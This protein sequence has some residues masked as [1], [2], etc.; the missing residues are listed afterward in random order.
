MTEHETKGHE[1]VVASMF[2]RIAPGYD[3]ANRL[4]SLGVDTLWRQRL[5]RRV[6]EGFSL[7]SGRKV[8]DLAAGTLDVSLALARRIPGVTVAATD[9][10]LPMLQAG[11]RKL[12]RADAYER[13]RIVR[14]TG[15]ALALPLKTDSMNAVT[16]AFGLRNMRPRARALA[17]AHR[18]LC[19]GGRL[20]VLE[21]GSAKGR[22]WG[23][24]YNWYLQTLLPFL[25]GAITGDREAYRYL[26][27]TVTDFPPAQELGREMEEAGFTAVTWEK[28]W[29]GIVFL[30]AAEKPY[31][32]SGKQGDCE[33]VRS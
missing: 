7:R 32:E 9:F 33:Q 1:S 21:F 14:V 31:P 4:L 16:V 13:D 23:G 30:H 26:A 18:V 5:V 3:R 12:A 17:E 19:P 6:E 29:G 10:C 27:Q 24:L 25:G 28:L 22:I 2:S 11:G 15:D 20:Y 8:L